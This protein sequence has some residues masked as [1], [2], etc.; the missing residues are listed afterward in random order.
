MRVEIFK[1]SQY[2]ECLCSRNKNVAVTTITVTKS[3]TRKYCRVLEVFCQ[4]SDNTETQQV[5]TAKITFSLEP[6]NW[7]VSFFRAEAGIQISIEC[8]C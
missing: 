1:K 5:E 8:I 4:L 6:Q 3:L 2:Q 7:K